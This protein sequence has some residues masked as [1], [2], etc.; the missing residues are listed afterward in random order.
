MIPFTLHNTYMSLWPCGKNAWEP[1]LKPEPKT[2]NP[3][4]PPLAPTT[5]PMVTE[6]A[7]SGSDFLP[8]NLE[9]N[10]QG[11][12]A[13][14]HATTTAG[15][16]NPLKRT[17]SEVDPDSDRDREEASS[18]ERTLS[19]RSP[20]PP[21]IID[22]TTIEPSD[23]DM[24]AEDQQAP[25]N[26]PPQITPPQ[27]PPPQ[28]PPPHTP[29]NTQKSIINPF[30]L[31]S[32]RRQEK[33]VKAATGLPLTP[34]PPEGWPTLHGKN[35]CADWENIHAEQASTIMA[36][37]EK[38]DP[39]RKGAALARVFYH[40]AF[41]NTS[42]V[43]NTIATRIESVI[44]R[45]TGED[46]VR[47]VPPN[48][49]L[50]FRYLDKAPFVYFVLFLS[51]SA[52]DSLT[53]Q[54]VWSTPEVSF[55]IS[56]ISDPPRVQTYLGSVRNLLIRDKNDLAVLRNSL[57]GIVM[58]PLYPLL[59]SL[60]SSR[61]DLAGLDESERIMK[62]LDTVELASFMI[63]EYGK[64]VQY[65]QVYMTPPSEPNDRSDDEWEELVDAFSKL[66]FATTYNGNGEYRNHL[67]CGLC[68]SI[69][70]PFRACPFPNIPGWFNPTPIREADELREDFRL[71]AP[72]KAQKRRDGNSQPNRQSPAPQ[73]GQRN[74]PRGGYSSD[75]K[76]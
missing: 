3:C 64:D 73:H 36:D 46:A 51:Q 37:I 55:A 38:A 75:R 2:S 35:S 74:P 10:S 59:L 7:P 48:P 28:T 1:K 61:Q 19:P 21:R 63:G 58:K 53:R 14:I 45:H 25:P 71:K 72:D 6:P 68:H 49:T 39:S 60:S 9:A 66:K 62:I 54:G 76:Y 65:V 4:P 34:V 32:L 11:T 41:P 47:V 12:E 27:L 13:S 24:D 44:A 42:T 17:H 50:S 20:H 43:P 22:P 33:A 16:T 31:K 18:V 30:I 26:P 70:H 56:D 5:T 40:G 57:T 69:D 8:P 15:S 29:T 67:T 52:L 23:M